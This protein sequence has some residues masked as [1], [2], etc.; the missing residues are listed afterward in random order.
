VVDKANNGKFN[1]FYVMRLTKN[2]L[3][4]NNNNNNLNHYH[5]GLSARGF[6]PTAGFIGLAE[7]SLI[8]CV[9]VSPMKVDHYKAIEKDFVL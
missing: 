7:P 3:C 4:N 6:L 1:C 8:P 5:K 9:F 2:T